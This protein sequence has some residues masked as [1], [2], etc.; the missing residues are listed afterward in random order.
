M[1]TLRFLLALAT[2]VLL[3]WFLGSPQ[4]AGDKTLPA[5]GDFFNPFTGF[6]RNAEPVV[7]LGSGLGKNLKLPGLKGKVDVVYDDLMVPHIFA[8]QLEDAARV[9]GYVTAANRLWQMDITTRKAAGRLSEVLGDRTLKIDRVERRRGMVFAAENCLMGWKKDPATFSLMQAYADGVNAY[10]DQLSPADYPIEFK[11]LG[12]KPEPWSMLKTALVIEAM[13]ET[14]AAGDNDLNATNALASFGR[15]AFDSLYPQW[16]PKQKPIIPD[17]GQWKDI[18]PNLP[19]IAPTNASL[20]GIEMPEDGLFSDALQQE[21]PEGY[22]RGSNNWA[23]GRSRTKD[24]HAM[25]ANDPHLNLTLPSIWYQVQIHTPQMNCYGVS[26][27]GIAG[28]VIGFNDDIAWGV[29]NVSHDVSDWFKIQWANPEHTQYTVDGEQREVRKKI[30]EIVV[31]GKPTVY[32]TVRYTIFGPVVY[33]FDPK[34]PLH[35]CA[36][37]WVSHDEPHEN[38]VTGFMQ[39]NAGKTFDDYKNAIS[40]FDCP[41]QNFV[42]ATRSGDIAIR[43]QGHFPLRAKEQGRFVLDGNRSQ[44]MWQDYIP[45]DQIPAMKNPERDFVFSANQH[46]TPPTYPYYYIGNFDAFRGRRIYQRLD[47]LHGATVDSMKQMQLDNYSQRAAD[48]LPVM[49]HLLDYKRIN[50]SGKELVTEMAGWNFKFDADK[51]APTYFDTWWDSCYV[52]VWDEMATLQKADKPVNYPDAWRTIEMMEKDSMNRFFDHPNT[53]AQETARDIV[54]EAFLAMQD[55]FFKNPL[56]KTTWGK[57]KGFEIKHLAQLDAFSRLDVVVG[58]HK[59]APNAIGKSH[60]PSWRMIVDLGDS[61]H[62]IGVFPGGQSGNPGSKYYDNMVDTWAKGEYFDLLVLKS[63]DEKS[64]RI[65][66]KN[67]FNPQ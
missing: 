9:Q 17:M 23:I 24:G 51:T 45:Q 46:S 47:G 13:A 5:L 33:D 58:G 19:A 18:K 32:D 44:N 2:T 8:E 12:Y 3:I 39:L 41:A 53:P 62:G 54:T 25:L 38:M 31:K 6:W 34:H 20:T 64:D 10:I 15:P 65:I 30:E 42:F 4:K 28:V 37:R 59:T 11:L 52:K 60:G 48:A 66:G 7:S 1:R 50:D 56:Q 57:A 35:D 49:L 22:L 43:V 14:L 61:V 16:N 63:A 26:L 29:T 55:Y 40:G 67:T 36:L 21:G 27:P